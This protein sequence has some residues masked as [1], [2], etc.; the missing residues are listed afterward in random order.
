MKNI[1]ATAIA[2][3]IATSAVANNPSST[4]KWHGSTGTDLYG[5]YCAFN[6]PTVGEMDYDADTKKWTTTKDAEITVTARKISNL[7]VD[8]QGQ[9]YKS[10]SPTDVNVNVDLRDSWVTV[11]G[12]GANDVKN[13]ATTNPTSTAQITGGFPT[14]GSGYTTIK[15]KL[16]GTAKVTNPNSLL[17]NSAYQVHHKITCTL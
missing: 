12:A 15:V 11:T 14:S 9:L 7:K 2:L 13:S 10:M 4:L 17:E 6:S 16:G 5:K 3:T 8:S 1:I